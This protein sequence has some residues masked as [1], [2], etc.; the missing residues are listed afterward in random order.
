M[1]P[2]LSSPVRAGARPSRPLPTPI[3]RGARAAQPAARGGAACR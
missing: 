3:R 1:Q 2:A